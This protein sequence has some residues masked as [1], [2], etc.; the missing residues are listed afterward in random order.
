MS[1]MWGGNPDAE[2][3]Q[4]GDFYLK[5]G[6][7]GEPA[8]SNGDSAWNISSNPVSNTFGTYCQLHSQSRYC[9]RG[10]RASRTFLSVLDRIGLL[11]LGLLRQRRTK[12]ECTLHSQ[13]SI[14]SCSGRTER[15]R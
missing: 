14:L 3:L 12:S 10:C 4:Y 11:G 15:R 8:S 2:K 7:G 9:E 13:T 6:Q 1:L 5:P